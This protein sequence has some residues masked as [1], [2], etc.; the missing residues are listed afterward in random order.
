MFTERLP[1]M[2]TPLLPC[3]G[4]HAPHLVGAGRVV[5]AGAGVAWPTSPSGAAS[6]QS[7]HPLRSRCSLRST[8]TWT[9]RS[10][11]SWMAAGTFDVRD[12]EDQWIRISMEKGTRI[13]LPA[14]I[15]HRSR[16]TRLW[17]TATLGWSVVCVPVGCSALAALVRGKLPQRA[18]GV[19]RA[20]AQATGRPGVLKFL[21]SSFESMSAGPQLKG[22]GAWTRSQKQEKRGLG[23]PSMGLGLDLRLT[24]VL[25]L[26]LR[27]RRGRLREGRPTPGPSVFPEGGC[28]QALRLRRDGSLGRLN[29]SRV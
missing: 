6:S 14:G 23:A 24:G 28:D 10:A 27:T 7:P 16:L 20:C 29:V 25:S 3:R 17:P 18:A 12:R 15:Y 13:T 22:A 2:H 8:S 19:H 1:Q 4:D 9:R 26:R 5:R 21:L 11:T